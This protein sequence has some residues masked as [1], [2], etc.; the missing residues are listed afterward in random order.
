MYFALWV[1]IIYF[2]CLHAA[3]LYDSN[4]LDRLPLRAIGRWIVDRNSK[5]VKLSCI[6]WAG[7]HMNTFVPSGLHFQTSLYISRKIRSLGFNCVRL[8]WSLELA[9]KNPVVKDDAILALKKAGY[10][11]SS[12]PVKALQVLDLVVSD[13]SKQN[14]MIILDNHMSDAGWC[15]DPRD[16]NGLWFNSRY[17]A[18]D[19]SDAWVKMVS[20]YSNYPHVIGADL[21]N[22]IRPDMRIH[23]GIIPSLDVS[24]PSWGTGNITKK[25][26]PEILEYSHPDLTTGLRRKFLLFLIKSILKNTEVHYFDWHTI[27]TNVGNRIIKANPNV[28]VFVQGVFDLYAYEPNVLQLVFYY[29]K[30]DEKLYNY[31]GKFLDIPDSVTKHYQVHNLTSVRRKPILL[32]EPNRLVYSAHVYPFYYDGSQFDWDGINPTYKNYSDTLDRYWG[33][34]FKEN[35]GPVWI[36]ETGFFANASGLAPEWTDYTLRYLRENDLDFAYWPIADARP[37][38]NGAG[39]FESGND[40]YALLNHNFTALQYV[41]MFNTFSDLFDNNEKKIIFQ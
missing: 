13:L 32:D 38:I 40:D 3:A 7:A 37:I 24:L 1:F 36:G 26:D 18:M 33:Y 41:P 30:A 34:I 12:E 8:N 23:E 21:R 25:F 14:I 31:I 4:L 5:R 6:N 35:I 16:E 22:E 28:M 9:L 17:S 15:C 11:S 20:R 27:A 39:E 2:S 19:F 10:F 29:L